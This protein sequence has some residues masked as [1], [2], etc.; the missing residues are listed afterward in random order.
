MLEIIFSRAL[1]RRAGARLRC[2]VADSQ[3]SSGRMR[4]L[5]D[6]AVIPFMANQRRGEAVLRVDRKF[7]THGPEE[8]RAEYHKH[9]AVEAAYAFLK[10][11]YGARARRKI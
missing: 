3:Y 7:R 4:G 10:T 6:E 8:E 11:Q 9:P 5:V 1:L 2:M